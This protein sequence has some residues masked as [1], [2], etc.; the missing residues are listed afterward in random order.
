MTHPLNRT[1]GVTLSKTIRVPDDPSAKIVVTIANHGKGDFT[2]V[3]RIDGKEEV[4]QKVGGGKSAWQNITVDLAR[5]AAK[6]VRVELA[7]EPDGWSSE[8]AY[9]AAIAVTP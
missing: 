8:A 4:R 9:W 5:H 2:F 1:T 7:N 6:S 3:A